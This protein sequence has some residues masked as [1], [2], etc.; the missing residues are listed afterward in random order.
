MF[1]S[2]VG[3]IFPT[4][5]DITFVTGSNEYLPWVVVRVTFNT[6]LGNGISRTMFSTFKTQSQHNVKSKHLMTLNV[7]PVKVTSRMKKQA[8]TVMY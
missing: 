6:D 4:S 2:F 1:G 5:H 3:S 8:N 7:N